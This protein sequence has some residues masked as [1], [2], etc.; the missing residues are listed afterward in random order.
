MEGGYLADAK[1]YS[2]HRLG[3]CRLHSRYIEDSYHITS[4]CLHEGQLR[5]S[6]AY[7]DFNAWPVCQDLKDPMFGLSVCCFLKIL[8]ILFSL[9][10]W[11]N[12]AEFMLYNTMASLCN[13]QLLRSRQQ[14]EQ[15]HLPS[16]NPFV[17]CQCTCRELW[18]L[19]LEERLLIIFHCVNDTG[20]FQDRPDWKKKKSLLLFLGQR[21]PRTEGS[22]SSCFAEP[23]PFTSPALRNLINS[24]GDMK[25]SKEAPSDQCLNSLQ[26][27]NWGCAT[28]WLHSSSTC[29]LFRSDPSV[30]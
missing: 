2:K 1:N 9:E 13:E 29:P 4:V 3:Y 30:C 15:S 7:S 25:Y 26:G 10:L 23:L 18:G 17:L 16:V 12:Q 28:C 24:D 27:L 6:R 11:W 14:G 22:L 8:Y 20:L 19:G 21:S 5:K